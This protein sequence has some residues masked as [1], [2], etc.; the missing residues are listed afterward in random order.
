M[1]LL[2]NTSSRIQHALALAL[3]SALAGGP[4]LAAVDPADGISGSGP[5][6]PF[7]GA[8]EL[9]LMVWDPV[10]KVTYTKDLGLRAKAYREGEDQSF[11]FFTL[12]Q[13]DA[14]Y[15]KFFDPL[16]SDPNFQYFQTLSTDRNNQQWAVVGASKI[17]FGFEPHENFMFTTLKHETATGVENVN[18][19]DL[20]SYGN[21]K[22]ETTAELLASNVYEKLNTGKGMIDPASINDRNTHV[23]SGMPSD[24]AQMDFAAN[25]SSV[26]FEGYWADLSATNPNHPLAGGKFGVTP[27]PAITNRVGSSS[28]FYYVS[29]SDAFPSSPLIIDEFDNAGHDGYWGLAINGNGEYILSFTMEAAVTQVSTVL[30]MQRRARTDFAAGV[31]GTRFITAPLGEFAGWMPGGFVPSNAVSAV[32]EPSSWL[33]LVLGLAALGW[34]ARRHSR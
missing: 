17:G 22:F 10:Q 2:V 20:K 21:Q 27:F 19:R 32:P 3:T 30:G 24:P 4:V 5:D 16:N 23:T 7:Y 12:A 33:M 25:G 1:K 26:E 15:Q 14:G 6:S 9:V 18:W 8:P 31:G 34:R 11:N 29:T 28:W 13:Q